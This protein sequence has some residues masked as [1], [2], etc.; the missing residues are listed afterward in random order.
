M[1]IDFIS[2]VNDLSRILRGD[3]SHTVYDA[4]G[5]RYRMRQDAPA[6]DWHNREQNKYTL[7]PAV[8]KALESDHRPY[9]WHLLVLEWPHVSET[10]ST[11][12]AYTRDERSGIAN[13]QVITTVG[14]YITRHFPTMPDHEVRNLVALYAAGESCKFVHTMAE[15]LY[16]LHRGPTS[17]MVGEREIRCDDGERRHPYQ[18]YD[19]KFGWHMAVRVENDDTVGRALCIDN[20]VHEKYFVRT[21]AKTGGYSHA[22]ERLHAWLLEQGYKHRSSYMNGTKLAYYPTSD[23][24]LAPYIDGGEQH[25][26]ICGDELHID[27]GGDY[28]CGQ[29][30]GAPSGGD[31]VV[32]DDC[33]D[34]FDD[35]DGYWVG[36]YE[37]VHVCS[38]CC[39]D[40]YTYAY[41]RRG[42]QQY[43][44]N[45]DTVAVNGDY[46]DTDYLADNNIVEL[47]NGEYEELDNCV[48]IH[49]EWYHCDDED[50]C[51][52]EDAEEH[53]LKDDCWQC[54]ESGN[55]YLDDCKR[56]MVD[57]K[58]YHEDHA[59]EQTTEEE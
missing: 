48:E 13:R 22:D 26:D 14:K 59:P 47:A 21:Y 19:P 41:S 6:R 49:G 3:A 7:H 54:E 53:R 31:R 15:M 17:C 29:T 56:V 8:V 39:D 27:C 5:Y 37:D 32:C 46:Y 25:V 57:C 20:G 51:Y 58:F 9:N 4:V 24:F 50:V 1:K 33:G 55:W 34:R 42:N 16:H 35:G 2:L 40:N 18:V 36:A 30:G 44:R 10:D 38:T 28:E 11:R 12:L 45:D 52:A 23:D 43:I